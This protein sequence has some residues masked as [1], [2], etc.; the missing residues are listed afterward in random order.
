MVIGDDTK[1]L[2]SE[3][4]TDLAVIPGG[5]TS[6]LQPLDVSVN[7]PFKDNI[8]KLY[9]QWMAEGGHSLTPTGK[10][11]RPSIE[12]MCSW[13]V[14][15]WDMADQCVIVTSFLKNGISNALDGSEDDALWQTEEN[16]D[17]ESESEEDY[18]FEEESNDA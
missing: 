17:E 4:K 11:R 9:A 8:R 15:A 13:I 16:V 10:I 7:K 12:L 6:V 14:R 18:S 1:R 5:L 3:M 2:L